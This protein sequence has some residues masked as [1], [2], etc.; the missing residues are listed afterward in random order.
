VR[1]LSGNE[2]D[3]M[4]HDASWSSDLPPSQQVRKKTPS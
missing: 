4:V 2:Y 1:D 3:G